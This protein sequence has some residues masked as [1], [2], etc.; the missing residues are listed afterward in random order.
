MFRETTGQNEI[1]FLRRL[2]LEEIR[3]EKFG[4]LDPVADQIS[5]YIFH[6][7]GVI[8]TVDAVSK[9]FVYINHIASRT[10]ADLNSV[11]TTGMGKE[12]RQHR[13]LLV[14]RAFVRF[15]R[16]KFLPDRIP[17]LFACGVS[18]RAVLR[19]T[20]ALQYAGLR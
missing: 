7:T 16:R 2:E 1:V 17:I 15:Y 10:A 4:V 3:V 14:E 6:V 13:V 19:G 9:L 12:F 8:Q 20:V 11:T 18:C 5:A